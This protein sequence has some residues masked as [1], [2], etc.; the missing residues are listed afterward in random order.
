MFLVLALL[1][2]LVLPSPWNVIGGLACIAVGVFEV[3]Y[4][5]RRMR[6]EKVQT[7]VEH[8]V[9]ATG[10][11]TERLAPSGHIR[12]LGELWEA[13]SS[14]ELPP[15]SRVRVVAVHGLTLEVEAVD[16]AAARPVLEAFGLGLLGASSLL[17]A[18]LFACWIDVP[19]RLVGILA[20][21]GAGALIAAISFDLVGE[22]EDVLD[23]WQ[24]ALWMLIG[25]AVFLVADKAVESRFGQAGV[26]GAM[27]IVVGSVV[28]GV[29]ESVIFGIQIG[30]DF[31]ISLSFLAA[32]FVSNIPQSIA[33]SADLSA[34]GWTARRV[35]TLW[36]WV[37]L[38][39][40]V[41]AALGYS[42]HRSDVRGS[43][44]PSGGPRRRRPLGH[45]DQLADALRLRAWRGSCRCGDRRRVLRLPPRQQLRQTTDRQPL[46]HT[47]WMMSRPEWLN[48]A[49]PNSEGS[50]RSWRRQPR[51]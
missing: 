33:P 23:H 17:F 16:D 2:F 35:G 40:G 48:D 44:W 51:R 43:G 5:Q 20:G 39:C 49:V 3:V 18:G 24:F 1:L 21:F 12:V 9:G 50:A 36:F 30:T 29:P 15:G 13:R 19:A 45:A 4:W 31:P 32:V 11:V 47:V 28:D 27:G 38:A 14:S 10:E 7:G 37:V 26:G 25:V 41:A 6:R 42:G 46:N 22:A 34:A 8:L